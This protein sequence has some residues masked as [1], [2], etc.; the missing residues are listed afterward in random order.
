MRPVTSPVSPF[1]SV[2]LVA[3]DLQPTLLAMLPEGGAAVLQRSCFALEAAGLLGLGRVLT[4][5]VPAKLGPL[6]PDIQNVALGAPI[7]A[8]SSF[9][10]FEE[11]AFLPL[12][13]STGV[14]H[15]LIAGVETSICVYQTALGALEQGFHVTLLSD[16]VDG[17]RPQDAAQVFATLRRAEAYVLPS[18]AV[19]YSML[20]SADH[21]AFRAFN[22]LV[23]QYSS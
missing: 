18:E 15:I 17:R 9:S 3:V 8:K 14:D 21:P 22:Q 11:P 23:K 16:C 19:F 6:H 20:K 13:E 5:Q 1:A 7:L 12:L 10:A 4:V 2:T